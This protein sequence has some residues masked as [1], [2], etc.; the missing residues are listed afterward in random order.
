[1]RDANAVSARQLNGK[2]L[3][4]NN[5]LDLDGALGIVRQFSEPAAVVM[6][7][8]NPCGAAVADRSVLSGGCDLSNPLIFTPTQKCL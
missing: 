3:S 7:H 6:K 8:N 1:M 2:E 4:Y 5:F